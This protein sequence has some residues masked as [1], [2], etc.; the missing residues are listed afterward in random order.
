MRPLKE[1]KA[2]FWHAESGDRNYTPRPGSKA[3]KELEQSK[4]PS[5]DCDLDDTG[6]SAK[7]PVVLHALKKI[8]KPVF[9]SSYEDEDSDDDEGDDDDHIFLVVRQKPVDIPE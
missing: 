2:T 9:Q 4:G 6:L 5:D 8:F 3:A 1:R 7:S